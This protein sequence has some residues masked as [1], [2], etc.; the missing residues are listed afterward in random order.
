MSNSNS[1]R[2]P[3][4]QFPKR[5]AVERNSDDQRRY[6]AV[7]AELQSALAREGG[8]RKEKRDLWRR[9]VMLEQEL[10]HRISNG[11]QLVAGLLSLHSR[12]TSMPE[13]ARMQLTIAARRV[14]A[15]GAVNQRLHLPD[16]PAKVELKEFL[17]DLLGGCR[18]MNSMD[19][20]VAILNVA[21]YKQLLVTETDTAKRKTIAGLLAEEETKLAKI[22]RHQKQ[23]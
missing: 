12:R 8:L 17:I 11:L 15:L 10:E 18:N 21:H 9:H 13:E 3:V 7:V 20:T 14:V 4:S 5:R 2:Q 22:V 6:D 16:Q 19:M 1:A 23:R